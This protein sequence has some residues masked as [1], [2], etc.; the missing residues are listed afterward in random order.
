MTPVIQQQL[1]EL[2]VSSILIKL[3]K[4][5]RNYKAIADVTIT[6][7][8]GNIIEGASVIGN[9]AIN[10]KYLNTSSGLTNIEG[11]ATLVSNPIKVKSRDTFSISIS[12]VVKDG[13]LYDPINNYGALTVP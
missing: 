7:D 1:S 9:W 2:N 5:G 3:D 13:F 10:G 8:S 11:K 12:D 4:K 6:S